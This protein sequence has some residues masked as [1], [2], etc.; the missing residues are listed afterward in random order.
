MRVGERLEVARDRR[1]RLRDVWEGGDLSAPCRDPEPRQPVDGAIE[2]R[3]ELRPDLAAS[4]HNSLCGSGS[5]NGAE[6]WIRSCRLGSAANS[7]AAISGI[8]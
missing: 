3:V 7:R 5:S 8:R 4:S 6:L 2:D 1:E